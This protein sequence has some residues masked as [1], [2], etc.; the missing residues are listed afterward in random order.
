VYTHRTAQSLAMWLLALSLGLYRRV[1]E[2]LHDDTSHSV[3]IDM[4]PWDR[5]AGHTAGGA[6]VID[7]CDLDRK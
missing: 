1:V 2:S 5:G 4:P 7:Y 3:H 6:V